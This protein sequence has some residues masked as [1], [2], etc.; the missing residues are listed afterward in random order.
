MWV[1]TSS[2]YVEDTEQ[3]LESLILSGYFFGIFSVIIIELLAHEVTL[4]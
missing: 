2:S 1:V 4:R 3:L